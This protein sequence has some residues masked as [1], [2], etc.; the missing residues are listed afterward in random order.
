MVASAREACRRGV[1][2]FD[3]RQFF[4]AHEQFESVW[5]S[6]EVLDRDRPFWKG[7]TQVAVGCCHAQRGNDR[8]AL[9]LLA[10]AVDRLRPFPSPHRG[11]D[12]AGLI[13]LAQSV[14]EQVRR[15]GAS[16]DLDFPGFPSAGA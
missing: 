10:R 11:I 4:E 6:P 15:R 14:A 3:D 7:V 1:E 8:G 13:S 5:K 16:A 12:T 2:L 9:A